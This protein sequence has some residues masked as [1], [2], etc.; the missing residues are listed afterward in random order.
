MDI[1]RRHLVFIFLLLVTLSFVLFGNSLGGQ[2]TLDDHPV[3]ERRQ[4]LRSLA[5]LPQILIAPWHPAGQWAGNYRPLTLAT[6]AFNFVFSEDPTGFRIVNLI[7]HAANALLLFVLGRKL[8]SQ[9]VGLIAAALFLF[10][11]IHVE[12]VV[13]IVG[14][15]TLLGTFFVLL[16]LISFFDQKYKI[17]ALSF[18]LALLSS[19][20]TIFF[21]PLALYLLVVARPGRWP[22]RIQP[23][24]WYLL[25]LPFYF[26]LRFFALGRYA[27]GGYG[28]IDPIIGPLAFVS[29]PERIG[30][31]LKHLFLYVRKTFYPV[32]LSPDY[33]FDQIPIVANI[34]TSPEALIG[35]AF[36]IFIIWLCF[37]AKPP[38]NIAAVMFL[39]SYG[40]MSNTLFITTGTMAERWWYFPSLGLSLLA[41][42][43]LERLFTLRSGW[44]SSLVIGSIV[45]AGWYTVLIWR[46]NRIWADD[47]T[48]FAAA[49]QRSPRSAW[50]RTNFAEQL[51]TERKYALADREISAAMAITDQNPLT[52]F[53]IGKLRW[54]E[55]DFEA[56]EQS[57]LRAIEFDRHGRNTRSLYRMLALLRLD[58]NRYDEALSDMEEAKRWPAAG[59]VE[60]VRAVDQLISEV[61]ALR[62]N[63][64]TRQ[65]LLVGGMK[66]NDLVALIRGF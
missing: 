38:R 4:E 25:P 10:L 40:I 64:S 2:F 36:L 61:I 32:D 52:L 47:R 56:A 57:F 50:A 13:S 63:S 54:R 5:H 65:T 23:G 44:K 41:A 48:L 21:L 45:L 30:T 8:Y 46:Q 26:L 24:W 39:A 58:Q 7:L 22:E 53:V 19:D 16:A 43:A 15:H 12:P 66:W 28:F 29:F 62:P 3:V 55:E 18:F 33:S 20:F 31:A 35:L 6:F 17:S 51:F 59:Q 1:N 37:F 14:R 60:V 27:F 42:P 9:R 49:A 34:L 11:P